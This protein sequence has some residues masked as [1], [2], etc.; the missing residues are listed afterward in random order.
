M[1]TATHAARLS[2]PGPDW[3]TLWRDAV[4]DPAELLD[5][6]GLGHLADHL[7]AGDAGFS[8][9]VPRGF[10][11]RMRQG[12]PRDPL[13]LQALPQLAELDVV[14]GFTVDAVGDMA[15]RSAQG[16]LHKY[17]G[18]ALLIAS[19]SCAINCRYCFRRHF[20]YGDEMAAAGQWRKALEHV[21]HDAS[22]SELILSG[23]DPLSLAT[24]K[25]EELT[26]G[27]ADIPHI[28]RLRIHTRLPVVLPERIDGAFSQWLADL[29]LQKVVVLHAN[30]ANEFDADVDAACGRLRDAGATLL[31][32]SVLLRGINDDAETLTA[33]SERLFAAGVLPYYL[34]QLDRVQGAA[35]FEVDDARA[36]ALV[37]AVRQR[38]PGYLV[39]K[40]VR[41]VGGEPSKRPV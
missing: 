8:V 10:V 17:E 14:P 32:Q 28:T 29:P 21:R 19:G 33:L 25:L 5:L 41:E 34:H 9:R 30:H 40:L 1:I 23:G 3:R 12:D 11:A 4:T 27:L 26:Q 38:L 22:I 7:P 24:S 20:P 39:P 6:V 18:R 31:N 13:L 16:V 35:H 36:L 15:A 2:P 37:D